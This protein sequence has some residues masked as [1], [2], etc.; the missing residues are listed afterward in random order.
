MKINTP[1]RKYLKLPWPNAV[2]LRNLTLL[3]CG[4]VLVFAPLAY[5]AVHPWAYTS[6]GLILSCLSVVLLLAVAIA[7]LTA[8]QAF[9]LPRP[10]FWGLVL[11]AMLLVLLQL[12]PLPLQI[13]EWLSP[14]AVRIRALGNGYGLAPL[15]P[16]SLNSN[17]T[18]QETLLLWPAVVLFFLLVLTINRGWQLQ[19]LVTL[20]LG[21]A[22]GEALYGLWNFRSHSI[23]GWKNPYYLGRVCGTFIN[24]NHAAGYLGMAVLLSFGLFLAWEPKQDGPPE[25]T[26]RGRSRFRFWS[27]AEHLEPLVRRS[28]G[29]LPLLVLLVAFFFA[30]SRGATL[31]LG[32]GLALMGLLWGTQRS[33][34]WPLSLL[35]IFLAGVIIYSLWLG[36]GTVFSRILDL[37]DPARYIAFWGSLGIF[38][39]FPLLGAGLG[40]FDDL[41]YTFLPAHLSQTRLVYAHNE[42]VQL[43][44]EM[45]LVGFAVVG[46]GWVFFYVSLI[47]LW[48]RRR[49]SWVRGLGLGGLAAL[50]AGAVHALGEFTFRIPAYSL[51]YAALAALTF[52]VLHYH[53]GR[54]CFAYATWRLTG[55]PLAPW[56]CGALILIQAAFMW[57]AWHF[58]QAER[59]APLIRDTT[60]IPRKIPAADFVQALALNPRNAGYAAGLAGALEMEEVSSQRAQEIEVLWRRAVFLAPANWRYHLQLG[61]FLLQHY[62]LAPKRHLFEGL[63]EVAA[64]A[65]L[66]PEKAAIHLTLG[67]GLTWTGLFYPGYIPPELANRAQVH[68][69]KAVALEPDL[70]KFVG[71]G[72]NRP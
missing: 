16:F 29:L 34:R 50:A 66:F 21:V 41:S 14:G 11:A 13:V 17:A 52:L 27:R 67:L 39:E 6:L 51:T 7:S 37:S 18:I 40:S 65:T 49:D 26:T 58:R 70:K 59:A 68:L 12:T 35:A 1:L 53:R 5:G 60:R 8:K 47:R 30:A 32:A 62:R 22:L 23:W 15:I 3:V 28:F 45:G 54:D 36:K 55:H 71:T 4:G 69:D 72:K 38:R 33:R 25:K 9:I 46:G 31:G 42:W 43:L 56:L 57:Q 48:R 19:A 64:A 44:A 63:R 10:P 61:N 2:G 24:S 20:I